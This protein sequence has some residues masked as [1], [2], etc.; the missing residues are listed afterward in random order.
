MSIE[1]TSDEQKAIRALKR[2]AKSWPKSLWLFSA[3]GVL[4]V[5]RADQD[6]GHYMQPNDGVD[7]SYSLE[8]INIPN[9]RGDW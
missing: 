5:M 9:D 1:L 3:S 4:H 6:G 8:T 7:P 2:L